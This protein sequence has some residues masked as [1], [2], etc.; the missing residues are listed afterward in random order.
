[1]ARMIVAVPVKD[2]LEEFPTPDNGII[3][4]K[5]KYGTIERDGYRAS[6]IEEKECLDR[7]ICPI[8][9]ENSVLEDLKMCVECRDK[10][11]RHTAPMNNAMTAYNGHID[12]NWKLRT[13]L[14]TEKEHKER[15]ETTCSCCGK[16]K[17]A[18]AK[19]CD[20]CMETLKQQQEEVK[21]M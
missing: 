2:G 15:V 11:R 5:T 19:Y 13:T 12:V 20:A 10:L 14:E 8:C 3:A 16:H 7:G 6:L 4:Y 1:M 17:A 9:M 18:G 21:N